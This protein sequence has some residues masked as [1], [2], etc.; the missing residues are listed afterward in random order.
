MNLPGVSDF[1]WVDDDTV[2]VGTNNGV[3][4]KLL[5]STEDFLART[6]AGILRTFTDRECATYRIDPCPMLEDLRSD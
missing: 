2:I 5:L 4:G 3:F 1:H 6:R